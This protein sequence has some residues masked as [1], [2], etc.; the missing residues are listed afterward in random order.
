MQQGV[1]HI[2]N[3]EFDDTE[4][5]SDAKQFQSSELIQSV[6]VGQTIV[7]KRKLNRVATTKCSSFKNSTFIL[8]SNQMQYSSQ[9]QK[10]ERITNNEVVEE[11][12]DNVKFTQISEFKLSQILLLVPNRTSR[13][14]LKFQLYSTQDFREKQ[15]SND[16]KLSIVLFK[17]NQVD[18]QIIYIIPNLK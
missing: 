15:D 13:K 18:I 3:T 9:Q 17:F 11:C 12:D 1:G 8:V 2:S 7:Q 10:S 5:V 14:L 16:Y 6:T 4:T